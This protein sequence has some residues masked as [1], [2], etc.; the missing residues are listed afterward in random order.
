MNSSI[1]M[2][3]ILLFYGIE[4][5][6]FKSFNKI[7]DYEKMYIIIGEKN[8]LINLIENEV[9]KEII[10]ILP[11][12]TKI[13]EESLGA[14]HILFKTHMDSVDLISQKDTLIKAN[15]GDLMLFKGKELILFN[16]TSKLSNNEDYIKIGNSEE[17]EELINCMKE[18][19]TIYL[20][21]SLNYNSQEGKVKPY[22]YYSS[23]FNYFTWKIFTFICFLL[24]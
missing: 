12:K 14:K 1:Y 21:N 24:I 17:A 18:N 4:S 5:K 16:E 9:T 11:L 2:I 3:Y 10:N 7:L 8:F 19:R 23:L 6:S 13:K 20:W 15:K 22:G